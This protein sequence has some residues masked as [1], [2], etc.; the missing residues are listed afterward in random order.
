MRLWLDTETFSETPIKAGLY[1]YAANAEVMLLAWAVDEG[2]VKVADLTAGRMPQ[3]FVDALRDAEEIWAH[4]AQFDRAV[5]RTAGWAPAL[6]RWRC[7][8][9]QALSHSLPGS[10]DSLCTI[11]RVPQDTAKLKTGKDLVRLFCT[12]RPKNMR[13]RR[14]TRETHPVEWRLFMEYAGADIRAMREVH[15]R[16]PRWNFPDL[17][18]ALWHLDQRINDRGYGV[19][20][21]L[22]EAA[23]QAID[24]ERQR[25]THLARDMTGGEVG[26]A[27]QRDTLLDHIAGTYGVILEDLKGSTVDKLLDSDLPQGLRELLEVRQQASTTSTSKYRALVAGQTDGRL[28]GTMQFCGA[29]RTGRWAGRTFQPQN[30]PSRDL[31]PPD[32]IELG[33]DALKAG[34]AHMCFDSVMALTSSCIRSCI[35]AP[36][37]RKLVAADLSNIEGRV[38]AWLAGEEWKLAAF[39]AFDAGTGPDLYKLAYAKSFGVRPEDVT[40]GQ[41]QVGKVQELALGYEGGVGAFLTFADAYGIDLEEMARTAWNS[42]PVDLVTEADEFHD[43]TLSQRRSTH[44]LS[45]EAFICCD[46]FKR[47]W[48]RSHPGTVSLWRLLDD[49][50]RTAIDSPGKEIKVGA[51]LVLRQRAWLRVVLPSGR[52]LCYPSPK[53]EDGKITYAGLNQYSR[54]WERLGTYGGKLVENVTQAVA[55]DVMAS[56]MPGIDAAGYQIV[57]TVHDEVVTEAPDLPDY[58]EEDLARR[59]STPPDWAQGLP[60][61]A[62]GFQSHRYRK[63]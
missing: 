17:E 16:L 33:I 8:M 37:G 15:R 11:L 5:L 50:V 19:D 14:A 36:P 25:L 39:Q 21:D 7:T 55:R 1:R 57:M 48:R 12:P 3:E 46:V 2:P 61:A 54:K 18:L 42:L 13:L 56:A 26:S 63:D 58:H 35:V 23:L 27:T 34:V 52:S 45:R 22:A 49:A 51:L 38:L 10:L 31:L 32:Q 29:G 53:V 4:N 47:G 59:M 43:W 40:K 6:A 9:V 62:A 30:L 24:E 44:G 60:L 41:R 20:V 28:R